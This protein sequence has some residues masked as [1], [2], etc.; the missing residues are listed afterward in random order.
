MSFLEVRN[1]GILC[2]ICT[3]KI[4]HFFTRWGYCNVT[5]HNKILV[6][7]PPPTLMTRKDNASRENSPTLHWKQIL[8]SLT[9]RNRRWY[10]SS[11]TVHCKWRKFHQFGVSSGVRE[12]Y[13]VDTTDLISRSWKHWNCVWSHVHKGRG[14]LSRDV[15]LQHQLSWQVHASY[16]LPSPDT[17][18]WCAASTEGVE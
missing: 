3:R 13:Q 17:S 12:Q 2:D 5:F 7:S 15:T 18:S 10:V 6:Q 14:T 8:N 11:G 9:H 1:T 16:P 4:K